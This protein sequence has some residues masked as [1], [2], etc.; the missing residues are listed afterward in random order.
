MLHPTAAQYVFFEHKS[1]LNFINKL[2]RGHIF[3]LNN[4]L[5][6]YQIEVDGQVQNFI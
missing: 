3:T 4:I 5:L 1:V 6:F 2:W